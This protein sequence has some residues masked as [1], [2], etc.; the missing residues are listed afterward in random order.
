MD[1]NKNNKVINIG[2]QGGPGSF[3]EEAIE[4]YTLKQDIR[5]Y[6]LHYLYTTKGVLDALNSSD[7]DNGLFAIQNSIGGMVSESIYA[8]SD[9]IF[10]I[11]FEFEIP[12]RH[13]LMKLK[14]VEFQ[15]I[16]EIMA[17]PQV[18]KQ[19][20]ST[21]EKEYPNLK[22]VSGKGDLL[23]TAVAAKALSEGKLPKNT[24]V[25]G[26]I[27]LSKMFDL[28]IIQENLQDDKVNMTTFLYVSNR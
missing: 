5:N 16:S 8:M 22:Q 1:L 27:A 19:C 10:K 15:Q 2:I 28:E 24:A 3:N 7:I 17:H 21:L 4:F 9:Y 23:D 11:V 26:P 20:K 25:L 6:K 14:G 12:I 18:H 13:M